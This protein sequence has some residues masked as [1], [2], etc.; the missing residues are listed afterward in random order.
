MPP[1]I[2]FHDEIGRDVALGDY[3]GK[4]PVVLALV[5]YRCPSLCNLVLSG[6]N[7]ALRELKS[8]Q[9]GRDYEVIVVSFDAR[10]TPDL[11]AA[12]K[13]AYVADFGRPGGQEGFHFLT[14]DQPAIGL[15]TST[16]GFHYAYSEP[17]DRFAHPSGI[18]VLTPSGVTS[19]YIYGI[20][21]PP[22]ELGPALTA[23]AGEQIARPVPTYQRVLLLC[24]DYDP[25]TGTYAFNVLNAVRLG[26]ALTVAA[27][28]T[29]L[30]VAWLRERRKMLNRGVYA[31]RSPGVGA[32]A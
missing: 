25:Q 16:V 27:I 28:A 8:Q 29:C 12:K 2:A 14:G 9:P 19:R 3:F 10:E 7:D 11:A 13:A 22:E 6:L 32:D 21:Y 20:E 24:Y 15:L 17:Q 18:V 23:A 5:Q 30:A 26:G 31:P 4:R 1:D